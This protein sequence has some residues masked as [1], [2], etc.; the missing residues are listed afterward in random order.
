MA[1]GGKGEVISAFG[2]L[3]ERIHA[4]PV[5]PQPGQGRDALDRRGGPASVPDQPD[6]GRRDVDGDRPRR[7][8]SSSATARRARPTCN[9][10]PAPEIYDSPNTDW[11]MN[12]D[13][14]EA[15]RLL[16]EAG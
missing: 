10:V 7:S 2:T 6:V 11:C 9:I 4:Q 15:N 3:V 1:A 5:R 16:D 14:E 13:I 12:A 8:S